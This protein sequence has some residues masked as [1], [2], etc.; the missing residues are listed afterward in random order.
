MA[1]FRRLEGFAS[2]LG[3]AFCVGGTHFYLGCGANALF[4]V[5]NAI[6]YVAVN[7]VVY[8]FLFH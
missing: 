8:V 1:V 6:G 4:C 2:G 5:V 7:T 3:R